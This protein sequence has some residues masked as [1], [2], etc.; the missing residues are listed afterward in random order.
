LGT[1]PHF[2]LIR[3][4]GREARHWGSFPQELSAALDN[5]VRIDCIDLPGTGRF[6]EMRSPIAMEDIAEFAREKFL[7]IR[8][9]QRENGEVPSVRSHLVGIS[10]GGMVAA[11]WIGRWRDDFT[12]CTLI[13]TSFSSYSPAYKRLSPE[14]YLHFMNIARSSNT[15]DR[16][17]H[18][19]KMVSNRADLHDSLASEWAAIQRSRPV[20]GE[21][22]ARQVLA[23]ARFKPRFNTP[24]L[25]VLVLTS[26]RDR[27]VDPSCSEVIAERWGCPIERH[28]SAGHDLPIDDSAWVVDQL[29][30]WTKG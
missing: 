14:A 7:E 24:D 20:T 10:L 21:N 12:N 5:K 2:I 15:I 11:E 29:V 8:R 26:L 3:G 13:N 9:R 22:L 19:L 27:M 1:V 25:P 28:P 6:S 17:R 30:N 4:L 18:I 23:A 16:E